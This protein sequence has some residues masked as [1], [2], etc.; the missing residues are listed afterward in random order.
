MDWSVFDGVKVGH[1]TDAENAT[2]VTVL[3]FERGAVALSL[4]HI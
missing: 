3:L 2:G 1:V 4:I